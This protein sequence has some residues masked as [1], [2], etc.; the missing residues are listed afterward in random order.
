MA[1]IKNNFIQAKMNK[2]LDARLLPNGQYRDAQNIV[3]SRT[4]GESVGTV[5]NVLGNIQLSNFGLTERHL[6]VVGYFVDDIKDR[7]YLFITNYTDSS[8]DNLSNFAPSTSSHYIVYFNPSTSES[9]IMVQGNF[10]NFSTLSPINGIDM[11]EQFLFFTDNRNQPRKINVESAIL[12]NSYYVSEDTISIIKYYPYQPISL[13]KSAITVVTTSGQDAGKNWDSVTLP[14]KVPP[15]L[16]FVTNGTV[17]TG[18]A[19]T[20]TG[21]SGNPDNYIT[22]WVITN[23]GAGYDTTSQIEIKNPNGDREDAATFFVSTVSNVST[24]V[25]KTDAYLPPNPNNGKN[26]NP[27]YDADWAGDKDFLKDKFIKFSYRLKFQD[28]EYSLIAPFTQTC[29]V[30]RNNGYF[31]SQDY[32]SSTGNIVVNDS[33][34]TYAYTSTI[35]RLMENQINNIELLIPCPNSSNDWASAVSDLKISEIEI[36][37]K[38]ASEVSLKV[39]DTISASK[40]SELNNGIKEITYDYQSRKPIRTLP[41]SVTTRTSDKAPI[42]A[43]TLSCVGNRVVFGNYYDKHSSPS[44][45][46]YNIQVIDK[47]QVESIEY[48]NH[49]LKQNRTYQIGVILSDRYGR[50]SDV[51]LSE[52]NNGVVPGLANSFSGS[53]VFNSYRA[54]GDTVLNNSTASWNGENLQTIWTR[55]IPDTINSPGYP[56]LYSATNPLGFYSYRLVIKQQE[57]DYYNVYLPSILRAYPNNPLKE[58]NETA[59]ISLFSDNINKVPKDLTDVGPEAN[60]F[61]SGVR[62]YGRVTNNR[63]MSS[64]NVQFYPSITGDFVNTIGT[65]RDL[66][67][68][69]SDTIAFEPVVPDPPAGTISSIHL[70]GEARDKIMIGQRISLQ[71]DGG[72][73]LFANREVTGY[74]VG[75]S[76]FNKSTVTFSP[77][78]AFT[79]ATDLGTVTFQLSPFYNAENNPLIARISTTRSTQTPTIGSTIGDVVQFSGSSANYFPI[80]LAVYETKPVASNLDIFY[81]TTSSGLIDELNTVITSND[82]TTAYSFSSA[83]FNWFENMVGGT[84]LSTTIYPLNAA[85]IPI[86]DNTAIYTLNSVEEFQSSASTV[87]PNN[88]GFELNTDGNGGFFVKLKNSQSGESFSYGEGDVSNLRF[89]RFT[90]T[91]G[92]QV[93][94]NFTGSFDVVLSNTIPSATFTNAPGNP[95]GIFIHGSGTQHGPQ[96]SPNQGFLYIG[97]LLTTGGLTNPEMY[98]PNTNG[99]QTGIT[100]GSIST[101]FAIKTSQLKITELRAQ[102]ISG[103]GNTELGWIN[104]GEFIGYQGIQGSEQYIRPCRA[105]VSTNNQAQALNGVIDFRDNSTNGLGIEIINNIE[106]QIDPSYPPPSNGSTWDIYFNLVDC[107]GSGLSQ[108][109]GP[110]R[111]NYNAPV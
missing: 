66:N 91:G 97:S 42:R 64:G 21:I 68:G 75:P 28:D 56:G 89:W 90:V 25:N 93:F 3:I 45:L 69:E 63:L 12:D 86:T 110:L 70:D 77:S 9:G 105:R 37:F 71:S 23:G 26:L 40:L 32:N 62:L 83:E 41:E 14:Y 46:D 104:N 51:I 47:N 81:E 22:S 15:S 98:S 95:P 108:S 27:D 107:S 29:F 78:Y 57:Q 44:T 101:D 4:E 80:K 48:A 7:V 79:G 52:V 11:I 58:P 85:N 76:G 102:C 6:E 73:T 94:G 43:E 31:L 100:N 96:D 39:V 20:I 65:Q 87:L 99:Q 82:A 5:Q 30:P 17:G 55:A 54:L 38:D 33:D 106:P 8:S 19:I 2:D 67:I 84:Q 53:T 74:S 92:S 16:I 88:G 34:E 18:F 1:E 61:R 109:F 111:F 103:G 10:L 13:I 50:Q 49:T 24:M 72:I 36:I 59:H 35:N 60:E